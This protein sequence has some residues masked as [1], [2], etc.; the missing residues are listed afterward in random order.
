MRKL[1]LFSFFLF[2]FFPGFA[3]SNEAF[4]KLVKEGVALHDE[5]K[6]EEA[7]RKFDE[8]IAIEDN[9]LA[10]YEKGLT[11]QHAK[12]YDESIRQYQSI[13]SR[14]SGDPL[15]KNVYSNYGSVLDD[16]GRSS[17]AIKIYEEG[18]KKYP[19]C[20]LLHFNKGLTLQRM[21]KYEEALA[22]Y[23]AAMEANP[24]HSTSNLLTGIL[25]VRENKI[26]AFLAFLTFLAIEPET[27]RSEQAFAGIEEI[28]GRGI[29]KEGDKTSIYLDASL[30]DKKKT[31]K[32][33]DFSNAEFFFT[34]MAGLGTSK[35]M[36]S[37]ADKPAQKFDLQLQMLISS[38]QEHRKKAKG[39]YWSHYVPFFVEMK[40]KNLT[41]TLSY[42]VHYLSD[43]NAAAWVKLNGDK[44]DT[45]Y[46]W[47]KAYKWNR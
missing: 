39:F 25:L 26:P 47:F 22:D 18:I 27:K 23:A 45:F 8:A 41:L 20:Y 28:M 7:I 44:V 4:M 38:L 10:N 9:V 24:Y 17:E 42:L 14:F 34:M 3:Q 32:E 46:S 12:R 2:F 31:K 21:K 36:D 35:S 5:G 1:L 19:D 16:M 15:L 43:A 6:Y 40:E 33:N 13:L 30:L 11:L 29:K 37:L